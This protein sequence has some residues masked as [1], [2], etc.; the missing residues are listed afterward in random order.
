M[1]PGEVESNELEPPVEDP[2]GGDGNEEGHAL[3]DQ[4]MEDNKAFREQL[5]AMQ[6]EMDAQE[7]AREQDL[8]RRRKEIAEVRER[9][10]ARDKRVREAGLIVPYRPEGAADAETDGSRRRVI[11][12]P[13][14][15]TDG[16]QACAGVAGVTAT[17]VAS[18]KGWSGLRQVQAR[19]VATHTAHAGAAGAFAAG[20]Q[21]QVPITV[22]AK[23]R[24]G[25][26]VRYLVQVPQGFK[27]PM[28]HGAVFRRHGVT[29]AITNGNG[30]QFMLPYQAAGPNA[31]M[32]TSRV[33]GTQ[34]SYVPLV[35]GAGAPMY[36]G[37]QQASIRAPAGMAYP[38]LAQSSSSAFQLPPG[39]LISAQASAASV[40]RPSVQM[41]SPSAPQPPTPAAT[42]VA[43]PSGSLLASALFP[44]SMMA[45][46]RPS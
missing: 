21:G 26:K 45:P 36:M 10:E 3:I 1:D 35:N 7:K 19:S 15:S 27:G 8:E 14:R 31:L 4:L 32:K 38:Q 37:G 28:P 41:A 9:Q 46:G 39:A 30:G 25:D 11:W 34:F 18:T 16:A 12:P 20:A 13:R 33:N 24:Q 42:P 2:Q 23:G 17:P 43:T 40:R 22:I 5:A 6:A 29:P 44:S